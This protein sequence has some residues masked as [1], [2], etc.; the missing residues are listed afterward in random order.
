MNRLFLPLTFSVALGLG[1]VALAQNPSQRTPP[2]QQNPAQQQEEQGNGQSVTFIGCL[3]KA[4]TPDQYVITENKSGQKVTFGGPNQLEKY[5]NQ[6]VQLTGTMMNKGGEKSF[7]PE[8]LKPVS[9]S[10]GDSD[11]KDR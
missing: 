11:S 10:C 8:S 9:P 7:Q 6:T 5:L 3:A 4:T 2:S 1:S